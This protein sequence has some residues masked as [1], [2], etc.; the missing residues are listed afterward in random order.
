[1]LV[2]MMGTNRAIGMGG[3]V[4]WRIPEDMAR[5]KALTTGHPVLMGRRTWETLEGPLSG[6]ENVVITRRPGYAA[7]G[8]RVAASLADALAPYRGSSAEVWIVGGGE[9]FEGALPAADRIVLTVV[10]EAPEGDAFFPELPRGLFR[11]VSREERAGPPSHA[12]LSFERV[13]GPG[14]GSGKGR[15]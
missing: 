9:I 7:P 3:R 14:G 13:T 4:P 1:M 5:F 10:D 6:R 2:A 11:E 15:G 8:A 12:F